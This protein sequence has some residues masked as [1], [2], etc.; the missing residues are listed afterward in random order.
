MFHIAMMTDYQQHREICVIFDR[1]NEQDDTCTVNKDT[2]WH[3]IGT[4]Y[5][6]I[7]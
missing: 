1:N 2:F 7:F 6:I 5:G 3:K 4:I